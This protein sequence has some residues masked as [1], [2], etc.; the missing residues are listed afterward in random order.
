LSI[1][2]TAFENII[3][4]KLERRWQIAFGFGLVHGFGFSFL[5]R[6]SMQFAGSHLATSLVTFNI[7]V[8]LGQLVAILL[9]VPVLD[10]LFKRAVPEKIGV[11]LLS[12]LVAH[13]AWHWTGARWA[14]L[15]QYRFEWPALD[16]LLLAELLRWLMLALILGG[17]VWLLYNLYDRLLRRAPGI[18]PAASSTPTT[19]PAG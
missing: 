8:E 2:Y 9:M 4:P 7:G 3:G 5:L 14:E 16:L 13:S 19:G 11:I 17:A 12:A 1:V 18:E 15:R 10:A 6:D